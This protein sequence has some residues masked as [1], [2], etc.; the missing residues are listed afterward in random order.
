MTVAGIMVLLTF[1]KPFL[2][3]QHKAFHRQRPGL[4]FFKVRSFLLISLF[5]LRFSAS[6]KRQGVFHV[7]PHN[8]IQRCDMQ[9]HIPAKY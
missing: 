8:K 9:W 2:I 3:R 7:F 1:L 6:I 5:G 4:K